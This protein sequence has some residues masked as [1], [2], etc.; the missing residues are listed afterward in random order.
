MSP[1]NTYVDDNGYLRFR[2][3]NTLYHR[4]VKEKELGRRL[5]KGEIIH[6]INSNKLDN[7]PENLQILTAKEHY[8]I[9]VVPIGYDK[10]TIS[11][12]FKLVQQTR[13]EAQISERLVPIIEERA[14]R[15]IL[16][17]FSCLGVFLFVLGLIFRTRLEM[18]YFGLIFLVASLV[19]WLLY[20]VGK[21]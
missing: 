17:G 10:Y 8:K 13:R 14:S 6:H 21:K 1:S 18:W 4:W 11:V 19:G 15:V 3:S 16:I 9:H 12:N 20:K 2:D 7:K 5:E